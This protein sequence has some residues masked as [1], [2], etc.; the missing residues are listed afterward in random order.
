MANQVEPSL[1]PALFEELQSERFVTLSTV[2]HETLGPNVSAIS[3]I[4]AKDEQTLLFAVDQRSRIVENIK[5]NPLVVV[6]LIANES[7]YSIG[8]K[9]SVYHEKLS[10]VPLKLTLI[11]LL[12][13]E[14]RDV[15][16]Y[17][18]KISTEPVYEKTYDKTAA[19]RLDRQVIEAM[20]RA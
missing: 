2:D 7:T 18:S 10:G 11:Q 12:I 14:V 16:F 20:K 19:D 1:I 9:A 6:N 3:W 15:M 4:Y 8:G 17:G 13:N 5:G